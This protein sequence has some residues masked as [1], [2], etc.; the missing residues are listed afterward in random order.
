MTQLANIAP[1]DVVLEVGTGSSYHAAILAHLA[2]KVCIIEIIPQLAEAVAK[3]LKDL[4]YDSV[5][6]RLGDGYAGWPDCGPFDAIIVT[7][8][9]G[10]VPPPLIEQLNVGGR[11]VMPVGPAGGGKN[12]PCSA[13][14]LVECRWRNGRGILQHQQHG[15]WYTTRNRRKRRAV[16]MQGTFLIEAGISSSHHI[17]KFFGLTKR[18]REPQKATEPAVKSAPSKSQHKRR[19]GI[20]VGAVISRA[21][22]AVG[23]KKH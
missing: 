8:A 20:D 5:S 7:A 9:L 13:S 12:R 21:L 1:D 11:L 14:D 4:A 3:T 18:A 19:R 17:A 6:I 22:T 10:Q 16:R 2:R 15:A 23:L